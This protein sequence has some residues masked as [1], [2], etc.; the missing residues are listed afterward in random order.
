MELR[1]AKPQ[2][3][4]AEYFSKLEPLVREIARIY[5]QAG[6]KSRTDTD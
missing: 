3:S 6:P 2:Y 5:E 1:D 4:E